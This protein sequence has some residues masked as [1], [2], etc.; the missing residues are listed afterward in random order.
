MRLIISSLAV[1]ISTTI[2]ATD[3]R[4]EHRFDRTM[5]RFADTMEAVGDDLYDE[6]KLHYRHRHDYHRLK[7]AARTIEHKTDHIREVVDH[8]GS[9]RHIR[10]DLE[11]IDRCMHEVQELLGRS[12]HRARRHGEPHYVRHH[13]RREMHRL[14]TVV[15][16]M[17]DYMDRTAAP[18]HPVR[19][20]VVH[21]RPR[22]VVV[23]PRPRPV[24]VH[25]DHS[26]GG[27][28]FGGHWGRVHFRF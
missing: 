22:P 6:V 3:S 25:R 2:F 21:P 23:H 16:D 1:L 15:H 27:I 24:V 19:P 18:V 8:H 28:S 5:H 7:A 12:D 9:L 20:V 11:E 17:R 4:A 10:A 14:E 26:R 13:V